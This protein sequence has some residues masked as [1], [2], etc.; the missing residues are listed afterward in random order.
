MRVASC[1]PV[2]LDWLLAQRRGQP[3]TLPFTL[4]AT[5]PS[6]PLPVATGAASLALAGTARAASGNITAVTY[7]NGANKAKGMAATIR[8]ADVL[9]WAIPA[10]PLAADKT[11][12]IVVTATLD[13]TW[14]PAFGGTTT[15]SDTVS[16]F[17]TPVHLSLARQGGEAVLNWT[18]GVPPFSVWTAPAVDATEWSL[19]EENVTAPLTLPA[20]VGTRFYRL[21]GR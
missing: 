8:Q 18:G 4:E 13:T 17:S 1:S 19:L 16:V 3:P 2:M 5:G 10:V 12:V 15:F 7:E 20:P 21:G 9:S 6:G 11:N 14:A